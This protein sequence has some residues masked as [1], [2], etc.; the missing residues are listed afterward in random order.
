MLDGG[1]RSFNLLNDLSGLLDPVSRNEDTN[2]PA[3]EAQ[4]RKRASF[5]A[6][7]H[8][9]GNSFGLEGHSDYLT[10]SLR[11]VCAYENRVLGIDSHEKDCRRLTDRA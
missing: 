8:L 5:A 7:H 4:G 9:G 2:S 1:S 11:R 3:D 10:Q 6:Q